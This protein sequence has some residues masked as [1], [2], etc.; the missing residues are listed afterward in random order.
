MIDGKAFDGMFKAFALLFYIS[1]F[2]L[3]PLAAWKL[4]DVIIWLI[5]HVS[6]N[7]D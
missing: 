1:I 3:L 2:I 6:I 5:Q 7:L 4:I